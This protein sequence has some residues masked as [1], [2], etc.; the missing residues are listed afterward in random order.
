MPLSS[1]FEIIMANNIISVKNGPNLMAGDLHGYYLG[2]SRSN[3]ISGCCSPE[4]VEQ[5]SLE[6]SFPTGC[7]PRFIIPAYLPPVSAKHIGA[8]EP[9]VYKKVPEDCFE[10]LVE[11]VNPP[12]SGF[13]L[14][15]IE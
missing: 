11:V 12:F 7:F 9:P 14:S 10:L 8:I 6:S 2:D 5:F 3:E 15:R 1:L 4:I 13:S